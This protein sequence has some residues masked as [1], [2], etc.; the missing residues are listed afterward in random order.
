MEWNA[1]VETAL[2]WGWVNFVSYAAWT[3]GGICGENASQS[4][5][6]GLA[7]AAWV[8]LRCLQGFGLMALLFMVPHDITWSIYFGAL[9][10][11]TSLYL[12]AFWQSRSKVT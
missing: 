4:K 9:V 11:P 10:V 3:W 7:D 1:I 2:S 8:S 5:I 6:E 12:I